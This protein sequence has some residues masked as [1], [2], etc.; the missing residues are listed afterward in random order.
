MSRN[1]LLTDTNKKQKKIKKLVLPIVLSPLFL[2]VPATPHNTLL[3]LLQIFSILGG[4][5][6]CLFCACS[7]SSWE[8]G[9]GSKMGAG[10]L[11]WSS[12]VAGHEAGA[13]AVR[14]GALPGAVLP[15]LPAVCGWL[16]EGKVH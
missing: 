13:S 3:N 7:C 12:D 15:S 1:T 9:S 14:R 8:A 16:V 5:A 11:K 10:S 2:L 4:T 6:C